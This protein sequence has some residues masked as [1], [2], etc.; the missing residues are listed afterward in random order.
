MRHVFSVI[1]LLLALG[2]T[3]AWAG[4]ARMASA[5]DLRQ[6]KTLDVVAS[7]FQFEPATISVVQGDQIRLRLRS[8]D[9]AHAFAIRAFRVKAVIPKGGEE[10]TVEFVADRAGTFDYACAEYCGIGHGAMKGRLVVVEAQ[11]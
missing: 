5:A 7:R 11:K 10:V 9:R 1:A 2:A 3:A 8:A 6:V 4:G